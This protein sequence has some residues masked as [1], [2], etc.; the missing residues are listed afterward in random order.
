MK[1]KLIVLTTIMLFIH[2][3][4]VAAIAQRYTSGNY[5][6]IIEDERACIIGYQGNE[7]DIEYPNTIDGY[8]V[9]EV[10]L[11]SGFTIKDNIRTVTISNGIERIRRSAFRDCKNLVSVNIPNSVTT[12]GEDAFNNCDSLT[13]ITIPESVTTIGNYAFS[14]CD[15]LTTADVYSNVLGISMFGVCKSLTTVNLNGNLTEIQDS[16]FEKCASLT[17]I[18]I[19]ESVTRIEK[20]AFY[21]CSSLI[22]VNIPASVTTIDYG[23]FEKNDNLTSVIFNNPNTEFKTTF[24]GGIIGFQDTPTF[25]VTDKLTLYAFSGTQA[26]AYAMEKQLNYK[27][28]ARVELNGEQ[29]KFD[30]PPILENDRVLVPMRKIFETLGAEVAWNDETQTATATTGER[31]IELQIDNPEVKIN[32]NTVLLDVAPQTLLDRTLV[33]VRAVSESLGAYVEWDDSAQTVIMSY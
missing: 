22:A 28:L 14:S 26:Q 15:S 25:T 18:R 4:Q 17:S 1:R 21:M 9:I 16:A 13:T 10:S 3:I 27:Q 8:S 2:T 24:D 11:G 20:R 30:V 12:I 32:G 33:P 23:A 5:V 29:L 7:S 31:T 19:P 6:Y